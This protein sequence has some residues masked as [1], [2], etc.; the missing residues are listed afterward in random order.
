MTCFSTAK[1]IQGIK[2]IF[3]T[4]DELTKTQES[5][6]DRFA[7]AITIPG[8]KNYHEFIPLS[9]NT[10]AMKYCSNDQEVATTFSFS[11]EDKVSDAVNSNESY[12]NVKALYFLAAIMIITSGLV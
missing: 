2:F 4:K 11:N 1:T 9:E 3:I 7:K 12:E 8:T 10:I 5:L 6:G